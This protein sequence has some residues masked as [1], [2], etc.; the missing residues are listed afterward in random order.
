MK[1]KPKSTAKTGRALLYKRFIGLEK[2]QSLKII[3]QTADY[4]YWTFDNL[5]LTFS[6]LASDLVPTD[7]TITN[8]P[9]SNTILQYQTK[10]FRYVD[11]EW[12]EVAELGS[13]ITLL[14]ATFNNIGKYQT[15][16]YY[17]VG[18]FDFMIKG[19]I[20]GSTTQYIKGNI[21][22]ISSLNIR[23]FDDIDVSTDDLVVVDG[24]L[25]SVEDQATSIKYMPKKFTINFATL[26]NI[27]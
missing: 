19:D 16:R 4:I 27:L 25:F 2:S 23:Y 1:L 24:R 20:E 15:N 10:Y 6:E 7:A 13:N 22:P 8:V 21:L 18:S 26:N 5:T 14:S 11:S 17:Y 9:N 12:K 3:Y